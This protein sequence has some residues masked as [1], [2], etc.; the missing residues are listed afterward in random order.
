MIRL[1]KEIIKQIYDVLSHRFDT[2]FPGQHKGECKNP[3]VVIKQSGVVSTTVSSERPLYTI[4]CYVP[5]NRYAD[6][7]NMIYDAKQEMK[8]IFPLVMYTGNETESYY[9]D[10]VN[11]HMV[12]FQYLGCRKI[13]YK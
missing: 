10:S 7:E 9:D 8:K 3:Y 12:S 4:M 2:Y 13:E 6:M 1:K 5:A 11:G